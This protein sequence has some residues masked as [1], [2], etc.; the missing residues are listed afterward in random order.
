L[1]RADQTGRSNRAAGLISRYPDRFLG[2][3]TLP[4]RDPATAARELERCVH[5]LHFVGALING[6]VNGRYLDDKFFWPVFE[7]AES[8]GVPIYLH[9]QIPP[10]A[11]GRRILQRLRSQGI[12]VYVNCGTRLAHRHRDTPH[13]SWSLSYH[14]YLGMANTVGIDR[15]LFTTDYPYAA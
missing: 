13:P 7:C 10:Q 6:H 5:D 12:C 8:L 14:A 9:P 1:Q 2:F 11:G 4:M 3:A 15:V